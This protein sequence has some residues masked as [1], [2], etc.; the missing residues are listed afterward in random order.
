MT[1]IMAAAAVYGVLQLAVLAW[2][3]RS[4][5]LPTVLLTVVVGVYGSGVVAA[6][7][8]LVYARGSTAVTG[9]PFADV[10]AEA[11][12]TIAPAVEEIAKLVPLL[13][14][15]WNLKIRY[16]LGLADYVVL[17]AATGAG[18]GLLEVLL[19]HALDAQRATPFPRGGWM[20]S[21]GISLGATYVPDWHRVLT[22]WLP[23]PL[24]ALDLSFTRPSLDTNL[25][26]AWGAAGALGADLLLRGRGWRRALAV[27]P[28]AY[29]IGHHTLVNYTGQRGADP[30]SWAASLLNAADSAV[31]YAPLACL[32][33]AM[34]V[35]FRRLRQGK[36][37]VPGVL[38][39][40][41]R[42]G[43]SSLVALAGFGAWCVPWSTLLAM[44]FA[45]LRR[46]L[47][48][49]AARTPSERFEPLR[50]VVAEITARM[51]AVSHERAWDS[52]RIRAYL[53]AARARRPSGRRWLLLVPCLLTLPSL[54]F[55][56][57][58]SFTSTKQI[59]EDFSTGYGPTLFIG[60]GIAGLAWIMFQLIVLLRAWRTSATLPLGETLA[61]IRLRLFTAVGSA[62]TAVL[63]LTSRFRG[64]APDGEAV[65]TQAMLLAALEDMKLYLGFALLLFT[66]A[67]LVVLFPPAGALAL[68]GG[69]VVGSSLAA[70]GVATTLATAGAVLMAAEARGG[71]GGSETPSNSGA[72]GGRGQPASGETKEALVK[73]LKDQGVKCDPDKIVRIER[74]ADG[75]IRFLEEGNQRAGLRH[76]TGR[77][78][79]DFANKGVPEAEIP[80]V[81][82]EATTSGQ[83]VG[84]QG[85]RPV[86]QVNYK[87]K[88]LK[89]AVTVGGN[90]F[91]V[92]ANPAS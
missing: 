84:M 58:G 28:L 36:R 55:L 37:A 6:L 67:T 91:I 24:G 46:S 22:N 57:L 75:K 17:G 90:G 59:Q 69:G 9:R 19:Q 5:R 68:V 89:V 43:R 85:T 66:V 87:G 74:G 30:P 39:A 1:F 79:Q 7:V 21:G 77:H 45:R 40:A 70:G 48:Y 50:Q 73:E 25:H 41:E 34:A 15:G 56:G 13:L 60:L 61:I 29:A 51:D 92:G 42:A 16:Q 35:D 52:S 33:L 54:V 88:I 65:P 20:L 49:A 63:L 82:M 31:G 78:A 62:T 38:L 26:L 53:K 10:M 83:Q 3:V 12:Y 14:I 47:L 27:L 23:A 32:L 86:Y 18:L 81:V 76:I 11:S 44:R 72:E 80:D 8:E 4:V 2:P 64:T 71:K